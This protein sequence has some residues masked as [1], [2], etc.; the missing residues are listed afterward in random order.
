MD[1]LP[2]SGNVTIAITPTTI[3]DTAIPAGTADAVKTA[4]TGA[5]KKVS[6]TVTDKDGNNLFPVKDSYQP[7]DPT[8]TI[9]ITING[10]KTNT[11]YVVL[12]LSIDGSTNRLTSFGRHTSTDGSISVESRHLS[13]YIPVEETTANAAALAAV[14]ADAGSVTPITPVTTVKVQSVATDIAPFTKVQVT[15][16][17]NDKVYLIRIG[18][19]TG[20]AG[21]AVLFVENATTYEFY[22]NANPSGTQTVMVWELNSRSIASGQS[23]GNPVATETVTKVS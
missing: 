17:K 13:D 20:K 21:Q 18:E 2:I 10:L 3:T 5:A 12:C 15:G 6:I 1:A 4:V 23:L 9:T 14:A 16:L 19:G 8:I 11:P 22:C 7:S